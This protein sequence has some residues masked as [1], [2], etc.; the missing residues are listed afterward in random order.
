MKLW[1]LSMGVTALFGVGAMVYLRV[2]PLSAPV[3]VAS[4]GH[5]ESAPA[6]PWTA[7][8]AGRETT[9]SLAQ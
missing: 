8:R 1:F 6:V 2:E 5:G 7:V 9:G 3:T 4:Q